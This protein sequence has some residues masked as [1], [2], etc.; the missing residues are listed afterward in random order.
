MYNSKVINSNDNAQLSQDMRSRHIPLG[1][2]LSQAH[3]AQ[4]SPGILLCEYI[5]RR[6]KKN[7]HGYM[8]DKENITIK[9]NNTME[10][11]IY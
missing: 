10:I 7:F 1:T 8:K 9:D 5:K 3:K 11:D 4:F 2:S 6:K